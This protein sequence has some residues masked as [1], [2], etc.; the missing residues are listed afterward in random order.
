[1]LDELIIFEDHRIIVK[2]NAIFV[3]M[4]FCLIETRPEFAHILINTL[5]NIGFNID[6]TAYYCF[7]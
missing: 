4:Y 5:F 2:D 1:M 7:K 3:C 6:Y